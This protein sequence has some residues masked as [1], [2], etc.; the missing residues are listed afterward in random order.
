MAETSLRVVLDGNFLRGLGSLVGAGA[1]SDPKKALDNSIPGLGASS[2][3]NLR[4]SLRIGAQAFRTAIGLLNDAATFVNLS[5][6]TL[7]DLGKL[8]DKLI[9]LTEQATKSGIGK[10][11]RSRLTTK[12]KELSADFKN[13]VD[14]AKIED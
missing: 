14:N 2:R 13:I 1:S 9:D 4:D 12:F 7:E 8:T 10:Q 3:V 11:R 5:R 6:S